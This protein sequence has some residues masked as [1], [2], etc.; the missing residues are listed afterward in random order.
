[1]KK[2][3]ALIALAL[4]AIA[5]CKKEE[6]AP[7]VPKIKQAI[8]PDIIWGDIDTSH[9]TYDN[10]GRVSE[11]IHGS[12]VAREVFTY[13]GNNVV[14]LFYNSIGNLT[15]TLTYIKNAQGLA[16]SVTQLTT[17][18]SDPTRI[19][20]LYDSKG[21]LVTE[22]KYNSSNQLY[23][24]IQYSNDG[25]NVTSVYNSDGSGSLVSTT[26]NTYFADKANTIGNENKGKSFLGTSAANLLD[27]QTYD[28]GT[29]TIQNYTY[30]SDDK[31]RITEQKIYSGTG[32]LLG[33]NKYSYY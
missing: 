10:E 30:T 1:M 24:V 23:S 2:G 7:A 27:V 28:G 4:L 3:L 5:S 32:T 12:G 15:Q 25:T 16:D 17:G 8:L 21:F 33:T 9:Y 22:K 14:S 29:A 13:T 18:F 26:T 19:K 20:F 11:I 31:G 6:S